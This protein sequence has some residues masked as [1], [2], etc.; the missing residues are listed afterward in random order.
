[1]YGASPGAFATCGRTAFLLWFAAV[2]V[3]DSGVEASGVRELEAEDGL[4]CV[5]ENFE[6]KLDSHEFR[7]EL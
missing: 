6:D 2:T 7:R 1:M 5:W 3:G 4:L